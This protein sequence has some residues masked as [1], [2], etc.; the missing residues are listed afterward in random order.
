MKDHG[1]YWER[2]DKDE[3][4]KSGTHHCY[5]VP[6]GCALLKSEG[7]EHMGAPKVVCSHDW[8]IKDA[9]RVRWKH[10]WAW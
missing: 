10:E 4:K 9:Q 8:S 5:D 2:D 1:R 6:A 3:E 7:T